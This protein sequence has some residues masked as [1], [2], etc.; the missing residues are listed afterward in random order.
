MPEGTVIVGASLAGIRTASDLRKEGYDGSITLIGDEPEKPY[1]RPPLS[2]GFLSGKDSAESISLC[3]DSD[4]SDQG[5]DLVLGTKVQSVDADRRIV[6]MDSGDSLN[7]DNLVAATGA[8]CIRP[9][10]FRQ[11]AGVH[12]L[13]TL[14][15]ASPYGRRCRTSTLS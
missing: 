12:E 1:D 15:D 10:W 11:L 5:I 2:K 13:R 6:T 7:F 8:G 4:I 3:S 9:P 14:A